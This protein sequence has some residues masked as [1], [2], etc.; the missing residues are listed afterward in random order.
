MGMALPAAFLGLSSLPAMAQ[1]T[2]PNPSD[3]DRVKP[4]VAAPAFTLPDAQSKSHVLSSFRG[5]PTVLVFYRGY[6]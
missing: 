5:T 3:L 2:K 6:W 4:G 1:G